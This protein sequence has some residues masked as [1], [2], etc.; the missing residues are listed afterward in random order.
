MIGQETCGDNIR[1][2]VL[3]GG[4]K[5]PRISYT[6]EDP[7][8]L[9]GEIFGR[10]SF[11]AVYGPGLFW[12][13]NRLAEGFPVRQ[14]AAG[15]KEPFEIGR[16]NRVDACQDNG[17]S[18]DQSAGHFA[19]GSG[20]QCQVAAKLLDRVEK[21]EIHVAMD[22][23]VLESVVKHQTIRA[24]RNSLLAGAD[25]V[26]V[27][28]VRDIGKRLRQHH[29][30]VILACLVSDRLRAVASAEY[31][32]LPALCLQPSRHP[33]HHGRLAGTARG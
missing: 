17:T 8:L 22:A 14:L 9:T 7:D 4:Q 12:A 11:R 31:G 21:H 13:M 2:K 1:L 3:D 16:G 24:V 5:A 27:G 32:W 18:I 26:G 28:I 30:F 15:C 23:H 20:G 25:A 29:C 10:D 19:Q 6:A 33:F